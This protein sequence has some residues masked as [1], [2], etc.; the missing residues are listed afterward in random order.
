MI[1]K[2]TESEENPT[3]NSDLNSDLSFHCESGSYSDNRMAP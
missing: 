3:P 1:H 2:K